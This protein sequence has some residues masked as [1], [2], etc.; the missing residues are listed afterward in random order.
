MHCLKK[1]VYT[2]F[3]MYKTYF[4]N[5]YP[6]SGWFKP[7]RL[8]KTKNKTILKG[9]KNQNISMYLQSHFKHSLNLCKIKV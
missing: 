8:K 7:K 4:F 9:K 6:F 2:I 5:T 3:E 1:D